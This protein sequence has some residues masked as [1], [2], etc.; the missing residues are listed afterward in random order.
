[1][2]MIMVRIM[3][4]IRVRVIVS[5]RVRVILRFRVR[6]RNRMSSVLHFATSPFRQLSRSYMQW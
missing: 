6:V 2:F 4:R 3:I 1:M 5:L